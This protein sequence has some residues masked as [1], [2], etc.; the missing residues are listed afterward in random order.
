MPKSRKRVLYLIGI[1][2]LHGLGLI[3]V[4]CGADS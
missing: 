1:L 2:D 3:K 4:K